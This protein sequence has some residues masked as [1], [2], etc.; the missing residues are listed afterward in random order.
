M[1]KL[2]NESNIQKIADAI[3]FK[4]NANEDTYKVA[5]MSEVILEMPFKNIP[6]YHYAEAGRVVKKILDLKEM[7]PNNIC[8]GTISDTHVNM[9]SDDSMKSARHGAFALES[10]G[11]FAQCDFVVNLGD[12]ISGTTYDTETDYSNA[13]YM[14]NCTRYG[15]LSQMGF[16]LV[17]NHDKS[18][19]TQKIYDLIG[20]YNNFDNYGT[21][22]IRGFGYKDFTDKKVRVI[23]LN[24][25]DYWN[26]QGGNGMSYEQKDFLMNALDLSSKTNYASWTIIILSHIPLDFLGGDYN[27][28]ADLKAILKAYSDEQLL[29]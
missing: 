12:N 17:G 25:C 11:I 7:Y 3:R 22:Q 18:N 13:I 20:K 26:I 9:E 21:T 1:K 10:V 6:S 2:Y 8:F 16:S 15:F 19:S 27:K 24:T 29:V 23:C 28:G 4:A 5:E 14:E